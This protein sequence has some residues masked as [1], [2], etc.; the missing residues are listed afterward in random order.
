M[1]ADYVGSAKVHAYHAVVDEPRK[2]E[3]GEA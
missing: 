1:L 3:K 2:H